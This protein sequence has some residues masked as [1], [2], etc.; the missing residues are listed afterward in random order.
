MGVKGHLQL[1]DVSI[2]G[3]QMRTELGGPLVS[4]WDLLFG[5]AIMAIGALVLIVAGLFA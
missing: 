2:G 1:G 4:K 3:Q 5:I